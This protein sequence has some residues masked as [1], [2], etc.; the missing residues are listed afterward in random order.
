[1]V[2]HETG[3]RMA[4]ESLLW[5]GSILNAQILEDENAPLTT[6]FRNFKLGLHENI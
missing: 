2:Y 5:K 3:E 1:M 6:G 4:A